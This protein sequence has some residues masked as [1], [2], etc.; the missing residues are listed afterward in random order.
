MDWFY[1]VLA[2]A[3]TGLAAQ[4]RIER[5]W[6]RFVAEGLGVRCVS[7]QPWV[8]VA[9]TSELALTLAAM[10]SREQARIVFGWIS[11]RRFDDGSFWAG[12][13]FPDLTVW[14]EERFTWTNA[15]VL[16]AADAIFGL[17]PA[18]DLFSHRFWGALT[19]P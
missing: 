13:T 10:G 11:E 12:F 16:I 9:E 14:P 1:P 8:T 15:G 7:D 17:T 19:N 2:G 18:A 4:R 5:G 3:V 6:R